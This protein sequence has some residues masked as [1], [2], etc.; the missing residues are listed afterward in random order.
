MQINKFGFDLLAPCDITRKAESVGVAKATSSTKILLILGVLAGMFIGLAGQFYL[1]AT[2]D[3]GMNP[4]ITRLLGGMAF[5][6]GLVLVVVAGAELFTGNTLLIVSC[7]SR[8]ITVR[9]L[10][11]NWVLVYLGNLAGSL[12]VVGLSYY[13]HQWAL[14]G[15]TL[16]THA[17]AVAAGKTALPFSVSFVR[18]ILANVLV[19]LAVWMSFAGRSLTD[20]IAGIILPIT[21]F[22]ASGFEHSVANMFFVPFGLLVSRRP[23]MAL[24]LPAGA[25]L[26]TLTWPSFILHSL[27]PSTLGNIVGG[28]LFVGLLYWYVYIACA[29]NK[30]RMQKEKEKFRRLRQEV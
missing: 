17:V 8:K 28:V 3:T 24:A 21:A 2:F 15:L 14:G 1:I 10:L 4:S 26:E 19:V 20:K 13:A 25:P 22:V 12:I 29:E 30:D 9:Q 11:R 5:S 27:I 6:L 18:A 7:L 16:G 23:E